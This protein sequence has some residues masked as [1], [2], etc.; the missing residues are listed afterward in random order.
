ML[1][2]LSNYGSRMQRRA[3]VGVVAVF[4]MANSTS[5]QLRPDGRHIPAPI[6]DTGSQDAEG[7]IAEER[8]NTTQNLLRQVVLRDLKIFLIE[9]TRLCLGCIWN[10]RRKGGGDGKNPA[11]QDLPICKTKGAWSGWLARRLCWSWTY[12]L[13]S[14]SPDVV[15]LLLHPVFTMWGVV[16]LFFCPWCFTPHDPWGESFVCR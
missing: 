6:F 3:G 12:T 7:W 1:Y 16:W 15:C 5:P 13:C 9:A 10:C 11:G 2:D 8:D 14:R 4:W